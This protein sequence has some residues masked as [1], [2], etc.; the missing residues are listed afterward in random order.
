MSQQLFKQDILFYQ[1]F[2]K[3]NGF[4]ADILDG[5]WGP[6]TNA[7]DKAFE[8]KYLQLKKE[9]GGFDLRSEG[10][11]A[12]LAPDVQ[13]LAR[14]FMKRVLEAGHDVKIISG[15]RTYAQQNELFRQG[16]FGNAGPIVTKA[17]GGFS[18]HNF[19]LAWDIGLFDGGQYITKD[20][21]YKTIGALVNNRWDK[22]EWGGNWV[23]FK[24]YPHYEH[25][26]I[27][28]SVSAVRNLFEL[29]NPYL[30]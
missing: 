3:A 10:N 19:G 24:D 5:D 13:E 17:R 18:N 6:N 28:G 12:T 25:S 30:L 21:K 29:G 11:I 9:F 8:E 1:R 4:Y 15:T 27:V 14:A 22:L 20:S 23:N 16:R 2:L 7:A 26:T